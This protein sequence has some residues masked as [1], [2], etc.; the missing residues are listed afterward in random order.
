[1]RVA[2]QEMYS[3]A[4]WE[5]LSRLFVNTHHALYSLPARPLLHIA[6]SAGL[7]SLK[8]P[9][10]HA[11]SRS[12]SSGNN[13]NN[14]HSNSSSNN[15]NN[16]S[17]ITASLSS[18]ISSPSSSAPHFTDNATLAAMTGGAA[19]AAAGMALAS[20]SAAGGGTASLCPICSPELNDL[21]RNVPYAHHTKSHV[22]HDAVVLPNGHIYGRE[23]L[24]ATSA[25][26]GVPRGQVRC[27]VTG[28][29]F[30]E[31]QVKKVYIS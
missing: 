23:R 2:M 5:H 25:K 1:M 10:C 24:L 22:E 11:S 28:E 12:S 8:T 13:N 30:S 26:L 31:A 29:V 9:A 17:N 19:A 21:A 6:L 16:S 4:R 15:S 27:L 20:V 14:N 7:S 3:Y 18:S